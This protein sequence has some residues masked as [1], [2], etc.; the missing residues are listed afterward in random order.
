MLSTGCIF[1]VSSHYSTVLVFHLFKNVLSSLVLPHHFLLLPL[2]AHRA[3]EHPSFTS[4]ALILISAMCNKIFNV[5]AYK[6]SYLSINYN[7]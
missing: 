4:A 1:K 3:T 5:P 6:T 7:K 2:N